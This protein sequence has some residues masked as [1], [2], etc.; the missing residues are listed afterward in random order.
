MEGSKKKK[1]LQW[2]YP[3]AIQRLKTSHKLPF[4]VKKGNNFQISATNLYAGN[5]T[6]S[7]FR[8]TDIPSNSTTY[9]AEEFVSTTIETIKNFIFY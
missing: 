7:T 8:L 9:T 2:V 1:K 5:P 3:C 6:N 4:V